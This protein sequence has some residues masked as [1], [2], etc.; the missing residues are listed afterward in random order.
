MG[1]SSHTTEQS[2][3]AALG[4]SPDVK[5]EAQF[6]DELVQHG[7]HLSSLEEELSANPRVA[8]SPLYV[9]RKP[10]LRAPAPTQPGIALGCQHP[11]KWKAFQ[12]IRTC[13]EVAT[14]VGTALQAAGYSV[15]AQSAQPPAGHTMVPQSGLDGVMCQ[16]RQ[17]FRLILSTLTTSP[18]RC[19]FV[20]S[21]D[22]S[23][24]HCH[25]NAAG[26]TPI[27]QS[28]HQTIWAHPGT[29]IQVWTV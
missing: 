11:V 5:S 24:W 22:G 14:H 27:T 7:S 8:E 17:R 4:T 19:I 2:V 1:A 23:H 6:R 3:L 12:N 18:D 26:Y 25:S 13:Q 20:Y 16:Q 15:V 29:T 28:A 10:P 21:Y 9:G